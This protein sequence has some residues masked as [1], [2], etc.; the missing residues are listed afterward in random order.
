[1]RLIGFSKPTGEFVYYYEELNSYIRVPVITITSDIE[2]G[3]E[4]CKNG[5]PHREGISADYTTGYAVRYAM[6]QAN[7]HKD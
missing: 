7:G 5:V 4:D 2:R 6:E 3:F 1:M